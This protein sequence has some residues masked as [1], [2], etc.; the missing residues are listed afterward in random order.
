MKIKKIKIIQKYNNLIIKYYY[1]YSYLN[2]T[3]LIHT[4][5]QQY[6]YLKKQYKKYII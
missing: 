2:L 1:R 6:Y 3:I 5:I 4:K